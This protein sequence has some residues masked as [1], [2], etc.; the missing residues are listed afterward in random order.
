MYHVA[1]FNKSWK[2]YYKKKD[3]FYSL[4]FDFFNNN[5]SQSQLR[6]SI[7]SQ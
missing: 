5:L 6:L 2:I 7:I 3:V 1:C 4:A